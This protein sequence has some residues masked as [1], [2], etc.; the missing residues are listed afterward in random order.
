MQ[1][2]LKMDFENMNIEELLPQRRPFVMIDRLHFCDPQTTKTSFTVLEDNI[3]VEK[4]FL[5]EAGVIENIAQTCATRSR[6]MDK[7]TGAD[8][9]KIGFIG[10]IRNMNMIRLPKVGETLF[11]QVDTIAEVF[12]MTLV[13]ATVRI[14]DEIIASGEMK[15]SMTNKEI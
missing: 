4:G 13:N 15:I 9:V 10:A 7:S 1:K 5:L 14:D 8:S 12:Q 11:T 6:N 2:E 3:F